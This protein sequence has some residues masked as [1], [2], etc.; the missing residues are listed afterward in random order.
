MT[1]KFLLLATVFNLD[2]RLVIPTDNIERKMF[3]IRLYFRVAELATNQTFGIK[4]TGD[5]DY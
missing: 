5:H 3:D 1:N 4:D 2:S